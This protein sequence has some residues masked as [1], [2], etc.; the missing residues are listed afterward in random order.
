MFNPKKVQ[1]IPSQHVSKFCSI[2]GRLLVWAVSLPH[3][4][5]WTQVFLTPPLPAP[6]D[7]SESSAL[8]S[9]FSSWSPCSLGGAGNETDDG[10]AQVCLG[11][12]ILTYSKVASLASGASA[13]RPS[14]D[15]HAAVRNIP[16]PGPRHHGRARGPAP[17][18]VRSRAMGRARHSVGFAL[19]STP[20]AKTTPAP[21]RLFRRAKAGPHACPHHAMNV[22]SFLSLMNGKNQSI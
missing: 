12:L 2:C 4:V 11:N 16:P 8:A 18:A 9:L 22:V 7:G 6:L 5:S 13:T 21:S 19:G 20:M 17:A 14:G 15:D 3:P 1:K 10:T